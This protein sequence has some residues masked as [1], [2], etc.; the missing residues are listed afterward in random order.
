MPQ[1]GQQIG[2]YRLMQLLGRGHWASVYLGEHVHLR[3]QAAIKL[4]HGPWDE[5]EVEGFLG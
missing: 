1:I 3:T 2:N 4:L 5:R